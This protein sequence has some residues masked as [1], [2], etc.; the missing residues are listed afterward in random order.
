M[1]IN[2]K[3]AGLT[4]KQ[5]P[6]NSFVDTQAMDHAK[7]SPPKNQPEMSMK[8]M[9]RAMKEQAQLDKEEERLLK[10]QRLREENLKK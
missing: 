5:T 4:R 2:M 9:M 8:D 7:R 1:S 6:V 3:L 10:E